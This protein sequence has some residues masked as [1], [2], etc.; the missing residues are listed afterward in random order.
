MNSEEIY[1]YLKTLPVHNFGVYASDCLPVRISSSS[2]LVV[3]TDPH[4]K[5]GTHW[6]AIY[7]DHLGDLEYF[8][9]LGQRPL[10]PEHLAFIKRNSK[11]YFYNTRPLQSYNSTVCGHYCLVYLYF[12]SHGYSMKDFLSI[13][14]YDVNK[15]DRQ[16]LKL[17]RYLYESFHF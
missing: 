12:R 7:L 10:V 8:D 13:F 3:N 16:V 15:N 11:H 2:A 4:T 5:K 17:F 6:I 9:S 1:V 14:T